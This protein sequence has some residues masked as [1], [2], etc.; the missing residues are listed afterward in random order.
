MPKDIELVD[1]MLHVA[2]IPEQDPFD[3]SSL[4]SG[5]FM[6]YNCNN[7]SISY[8]CN[9]DCSKCNGTRS[10]RDELDK[11]VGSTKTIYR[12]GVNMS[13]LTAGDVTVRSFSQTSFRANPDRCTFYT[14][15]SFFNPKPDSGV[16]GADAQCAN[17]MPSVQVLEDNKATQGRECIQLP[18][19]QDLMGDGNATGLYF[20]V[21]CFDNVPGVP[22]T[23]EGGPGWYLIENTWFDPLCKDSGSDPNTRHALI[24]DVCV[25]D[26]TKKDGTFV[27][28]DLQNKNKYY[29]GVGDTKCDRQIRFESFAALV[30][31]SASGSECGPKYTCA[32]ITYYDTLTNNPDIATRVDCKTDFFTLSIQR[33][34]SPRLPGYLQTWLS[35]LFISLTLLEIQRQC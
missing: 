4:N 9:R 28:Y 13:N 22:G 29:Y 11:C 32:G 23:P 16:A 26:V 12:P 24:H 8:E 1:L 20:S 25:P 6:Q 17:S 3:P 34:S 14:V 19:T 2:C 31:G 18:C 33:N 15:T 7:R 5:S 21:S 30:A 27:K 35:L 10:V